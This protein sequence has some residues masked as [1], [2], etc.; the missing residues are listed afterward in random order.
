MLSYSLD[1][2]GIG[3]KI[4]TKLEDFQV[5]ELLNSGKPVPVPPSIFFT[6]SQAG[7]LYVAGRLLRRGM[8]HSRM[9]RLISKRFKVSEDYIST[10]GVKDRRAIVVQLFSVYTPSKL[11]NLPS[12]IELDEDLILD[13]FHY[14]REKIFPGSMSGNE[15]KITIRNTQE[16]LKDIDQLFENGIL[17]YYGYQRFGSSRPITAKFG[18]TLINS[19]YEEAVSIFIGHLGAND[20]RTFRVDYQ[21]DVKPAEILNQTQPIPHLEYRILKHLAKHPKDFEGAVKS[22]PKV[23]LNIS[24]SAFVSLLWNFYLSERGLNADVAKGEREISNNIEI[25]LP[26]RKWKKPLNDIWEHVFEK[27]KVELIE[28]KSINHT[29]RHLRLIPKY[30][31]ATMEDKNLKLKFLLDSGCYATT[32]LREIMRTDPLNYF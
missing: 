30:F 8:D 24:R 5:T 13:S 28:L 4:K 16:T 19:D 1:L 14:R 11:E 12:V 9:I 18:R 20:D 6:E 23:I 15:F 32:M 27:M 29:S 2:R 3:G 31:A 26:S 21:N 7:G 17:N 22:L 25:A 10:A